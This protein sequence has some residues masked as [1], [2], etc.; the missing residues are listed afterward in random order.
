M[1]GS[2]RQ[3][4]RVD[5][6]RML[7]RRLRAGIQRPVRQDIS[8]QLPP[9]LRGVRVRGTNPRELREAVAF[10]GWC[11]WCF[12]ARGGA[13]AA[14]VVSGDGSA[15]SSAAFARAAAACASSFSRQQCLY[16]RPEPQ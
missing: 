9:T 12:G 14:A 16:F 5:R 1:A 4:T 10:Q 13:A 8:A 3:P 7:S 2:R 6:K 15:A 11:V